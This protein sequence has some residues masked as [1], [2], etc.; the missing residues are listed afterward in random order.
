MN[1]T[2]RTTTSL[3]G[4]L[5]AVAHFTRGIAGAQEAGEQLQHELRLL[6]G[7]LSQRNEEHAALQARIIEL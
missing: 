5:E 7:L 1:A 6:R 2:V 4:L 3:S